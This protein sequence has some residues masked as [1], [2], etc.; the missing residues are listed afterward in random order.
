MNMSDN[1]A[2]DI[3]GSHK[4]FSVDC[5]NRVWDLLDKTKRTDAEDQQMILLALASLWHWTQREDCTATNLSIGY[6]QA[7]R[8]YASVRMADEAR[9]YGTLCLKVS[10]GEDV[11]PFFLGYAYEALARAESITGNRERAADHLAKARELADR[12]S[13]EDSKKQLLADLASIQ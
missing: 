5:F 8:V 13:E 3:Q 1:P 2:L 6:W 4:F 9:R 11:G 7:S 10:E 12:V